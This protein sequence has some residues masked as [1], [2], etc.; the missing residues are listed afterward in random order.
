[1]KRTKSSNRWLEDHENDAYVQRARREGY[2]SRACY[3]L[4]EI[5]EKYQILHEGMTVVDL[6]AAPGGWSQVAVGKTGVGGRVVSIDILDMEP[7]RGVEFIQGDF[8]T[9][10]V[11]EQL[12]NCLS[13]APVDL[14]ISDMTPNLSGMKAIDKPRA[15]YLVE[16][17]IEFAS[18]TLRSGGG[19]LVKC[20]EGEGINEV[21]QQ[22]S[23]N[24]RQ[25]SNLKPKASRPK[26]REIYL[27]GRDFR[28]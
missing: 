7:L 25:L 3:K 4:L 24:F 21:R 9:D 12:L 6:G 17:A 23:S 15:I 22:F 10:S 27:L 14:V 1:M 18:M 28:D 8:T 2:R 11:L 26:S 19:L 20:F 5:D 16:L 13:G